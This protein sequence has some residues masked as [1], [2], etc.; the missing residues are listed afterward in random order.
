MSVVGGDP[1]PQAAGARGAALGL[2]AQGGSRLRPA[3][4]RLPAAWSL[5]PEGHSGLGSSSRLRRPMRALPDS[6]TPRPRTPEPGRRFHPGG[7]VTA[8]PP[9]SRSASRHCPLPFGDRSRCGW[10]QARA[11]GKG[12]S[13]VAAGARALRLP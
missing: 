13:W 1:D 4:R 9:R 2:Q 12:Q 8:S 11:Q 7:C 3:R 6:G 10:D 5:S